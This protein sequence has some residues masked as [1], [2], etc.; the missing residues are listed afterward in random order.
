[1]V[2]VGAANP[3]QAVTFVLLLILAVSCRCVLRTQTFHSYNDV[4]PPKVKVVGY[5]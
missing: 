1:M 3:T 4:T 5:E 2:T